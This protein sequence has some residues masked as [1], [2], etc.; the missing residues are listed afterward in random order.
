MALHIN[1]A[2]IDGQY[3]PSA[4]TSNCIVYTDDEP[5]FIGHSNTSNYVRISSDDTT[6]ANRL[7]CPSGLSST[8]GT[9]DVVGDLEVVGT[10]TGNLDAGNVAS[11][12]L[13]V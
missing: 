2:S 3:F 1:V 6:I 8:T 13:P 11:G 12:T 5:I 9:V 10:I 7:N 4:N